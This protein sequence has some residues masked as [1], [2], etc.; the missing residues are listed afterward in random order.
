[1]NL[2]YQMAQWFADRAT[3]EF[4]CGHT[5]ALFI[6][7]TLTFQRRLDKEL[8]RA[9]DFAC[10]IFELPEMS[11]VDRIEQE[12]RRLV[13]IFEIGTISGFERKQYINLSLNPT[14]RRI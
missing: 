11:L 13:Q 14:R 3:E 12:Y 7:L 4:V 6:E 1:M 10:E 9:E 2:Q 8:K 5:D